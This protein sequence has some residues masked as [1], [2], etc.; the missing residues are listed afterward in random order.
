MYETSSGAN[1]FLN[2]SRAKRYRFDQGSARGVDIAPGRG[3]LLRTFGAW[4][5][6]PREAPEQGRSVIAS[7][8]DR[9]GE[10]RHHHVECLAWVGWKTFRRFHL[11]DALMVNIS[12]GGALVFLDAPPPKRKPVWVFLETPRL[13]TIVKAKVLDV[14]STAQGQCAIRVEFHEPCPYEV[15]ETAVCGLAP[16]DPRVRA[17]ASARLAF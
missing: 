13:N 15:F 6:E 11:K 16:A 8:E 10:A 3:S 4:R 17:R 12:R 9:R 5:N 7:P 2:P 14:T 1:L